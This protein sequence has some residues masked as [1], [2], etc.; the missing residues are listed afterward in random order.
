M[1]VPEIGLRCYDTKGSDSRFEK[2]SK[3]FD[4]RLLGMYASIIG[5]VLIIGEQ[6][7]IVSTHTYTTYYLRKGITGAFG[8]FGALLAAISYGCM[9]LS[10]SNMY[11]SYRKNRL[12]GGLDWPHRYVQ[13]WW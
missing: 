2:I 3:Y 13:V 10:W 1:V 7:H 11:W 9:L 8:A 4:I 5:Y 12:Q 6:L